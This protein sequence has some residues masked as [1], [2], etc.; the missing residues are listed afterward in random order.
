MYNEAMIL[1]G[2]V[3]YLNVESYT[4]RKSKVVDIQS[5]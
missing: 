1:E 5:W 2:G 4:P 3:D